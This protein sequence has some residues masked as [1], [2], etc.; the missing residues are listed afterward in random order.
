M[1]LE[2]FLGKVHGAVAGGFGADQRA[3]KAQAL[4]GEHA[5]SAVGQ[6]L[7]HAGHVADLAATHAD[8]ARGHVG[9]GAD[10]AEQLG[11]EGLA[12]AHDFGVALALGVEVGAAL[13][14]AHGQG[15]QRVLE[16]LL[17]GQELQDATGSPRGGS[18]GRPCR[19]RWRM[20]CWMR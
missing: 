5:V 2:H 6:L 19:G 12:E 20:L 4:A 3:A 10:V 11:H 15:G 18:A 17:E 9:V 7:V 13:A 1:G 8:V 14:A 16:G